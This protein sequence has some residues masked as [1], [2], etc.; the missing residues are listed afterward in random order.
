MWSKEKSLLEGIF[1]VYYYCPFLNYKLWSH[2]KWICLQYHKWHIHTM[3]THTN[4]DTYI[5]IYTHTMCWKVNPNLRRQ[6]ILSIH[7]LLIN[8]IISDTSIS[9]QLLSEEHNMFCGIW[10]YIYCHKLDGVSIPNAICQNLNPNV[11]VFGDVALGRWSG[12]GGWALMNEVSKCTYMEAPE[13]PSRASALR[14]HIENMAIY[15]PG[16]RLYPDWICRHLYLGLLSLQY[17]DK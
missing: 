8:W 1:N 12:H 9:Q 4:T 14:Q 15:E 11:T 7:A 5:N 10:V 17:Y 16:I 2:I 13:T 3:H 6:E